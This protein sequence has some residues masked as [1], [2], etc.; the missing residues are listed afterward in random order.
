MR[1]FERFVGP[2]V[3]LG[4]LTLAYIFSHVYR[5]LPSMLAPVWAA[6]IGL[7][8]AGLG[9]VGAAF[10]TAFALPQP[11]I[12][13]LLD[14]FGPRRVVPGCMAFAVVGS[15]IASR[16]DGMG[17]L[18]LAQ[19]MIGVGFAAG[20]MGPLVFTARAYPADRFAEISGIVIAVGGVGMLLSASPL[21]W[22]EAAVG[23]RGAMLV[24]GGATTLTALLCLTFVSDAPRGPLP[25]QPK[26][27]LGAELAE[28]AA[29]GRSPRMLGLLAIGFVSY[30]VV[31]VLRGLWVG[32]Y[33]ID[34]YGLSL[35]K[36]GDVVLVMSIA[37]IVGPLIYGRL[38]RRV[39]L[40]PGIVWGSVATA[41][42]L[43]LLA[44]SGA[45][46]GIDIALLVLFG[47]IS[48]AFV[49]VLADARAIVPAHQAGRALTLLNLATF[50]G[51]AVWQAG[52]GV[53][54]AAATALG[55]SERAG[56]P[57]VFAGL[58]LAL[59]IG[60]AGYRTGRAV[61]GRRTA[62]APG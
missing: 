2:G 38:E 43:G 11:G 28:M 15:L 6:D 8:K 22:L 39:G 12:G 46:I 30:P 40:G 23:W 61:H 41:V 26:R 29:L 51:V 34:V 60:V 18:L 53:M 35:I 33:M 13:I 54:F 16:A 10:H 42:V 37:M 19:A 56:Y 50:L 48:A 44:F 58:A 4:M 5:T 55:F 31:I 59:L 47:I 7:D 25:Q 1:R 21:A 14:R 57:I 36:T 62:A 27:S 20:L 32:P 45:V 3:M 49:Y 17:L 9:L 52:S 24:L